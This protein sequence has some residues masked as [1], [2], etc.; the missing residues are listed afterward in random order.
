MKESKYG[1]IVID[2]PWSYGSD[3]GRTRTA[4]HHYQTIGNGGKEI[5]R[6]TGAGIENIAAATPV[7]EWAKRD[8]HL[9]LWVTNPKL[10]FAWTLLEAWGFTYKTMLTWVKTRQNGGVHGGGMGWFFRGATEH[11]IFAVRGSKPIPSALRRPNVVMAQTTGH[12][13]KPVEFYDLLRSIY[14]E[15]EQ[16]LDVYARTEHARFDNWGLEAPSN[17]NKT[18]EQTTDA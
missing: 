16:M 1:V 11:V 9:Y 3:T 5:N 10:P 2:P 7:P 14:P 4:E 17:L 12:S 8:A 6:A 18:L 13:A 15:N